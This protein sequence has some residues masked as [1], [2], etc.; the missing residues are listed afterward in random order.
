MEQLGRD[1]YGGTCVGADSTIPNRNGLH[2]DVLEALKISVRG[3]R[4]K[5]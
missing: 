3:R 2:T 5:Q 4:G 1:I